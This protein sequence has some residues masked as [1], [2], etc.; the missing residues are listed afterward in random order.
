MP[1]AKPIL[2]PAEKEPNGTPRDN[3]QTVFTFFL[4]STILPEATEKSADREDNRLCGR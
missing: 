1:D 4:S 3:T 2:L